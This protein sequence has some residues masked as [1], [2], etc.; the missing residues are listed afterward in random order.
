M[1]AVV[2]IS[3]DFSQW[4][5]YG[6]IIDEAISETPHILREF[7]GNITDQYIT[8][9]QNHIASN[10]IKWTGTYQ[11]SL[12][13]KEGGTDKEPQFSIVLEPTGREASKLS[14]YWS[15]LEF[16]GKP[17]IVE[18]REQRQRRNRMLNG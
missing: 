8:I 11:Q 10:N 13:V 17:N 3:I 14:T 15:I 5:K 4:E 1:P 7:L 12:Q 6:A 18:S 2:N 9:L 16:G